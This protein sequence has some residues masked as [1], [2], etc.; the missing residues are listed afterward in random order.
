MSKLFL[1][2]TLSIL[3]SCGDKPVSPNLLVIGDSISMGYTPYVADGLSSL[4]S[5]HHPDDNCRYSAYTL[6]HID[7]WVKEQKPTVIT[8]NNGIW[9]CATS[10]AS[11]EDEY[12]SNLRAIAEKL[13]LTGAKIYFV[14][15]TDINEDTAARGY[16]PGCEIKRNEIAKR[17]MA[18]LQ[19]SVIDLNATALTIQ[20]LHGSSDDVHFTSQ[21]YKILGEEIV[22]KIKGDL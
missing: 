5:V 19:I 18:E 20:E 9:D 8:W 17:V 21:G 7:E 12:E 11:T 16:I 15:T 10:T 1:V 13:M 4:M 3:C 2:I 6:L 14:T 22:T